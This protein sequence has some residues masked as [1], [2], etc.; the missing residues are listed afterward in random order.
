MM[1]SE[2]LMKLQGLFRELFQLD[3]ADLDFGLYRLLN[4][5]RHEIGDFLTKQLP[6]EVDEKFRILTE[7]D[8]A[9]YR[10]WL[11]KLEEQIREDLPPDTIL[12]NGDVKPAYRDAP[13]VKRYLDQ[14]ER[15][16]R[17]EA[18]EEQKADVFNHLFNFFSRYYDE[19]DF[20]PKRFYGS[21][22]NYAVPYNGEEVFF[23]WANKDQ[24]YVKTG[25]N[26]RDYNFK[27][28]GL[29]VVYRVRFA[30]TE[31]TTPKDNTKGEYRYFFP[32]PKKTSFDKKTK[33][34]ILPF[35]YRL[36]TAEEVQKYGTKTKGQDAILIEAVPKVMDAVPD[37]MLRD[38]L[39]EVVHKTDKEEVTLLL[40][41]LRHFTRK[42][43]TD[44]FIHKNLEGFLNQE[45]EFYIK[46]QMLHLADLE[47]DFDQKRLMLRV[48][49]G[50]ADNIITFLSQIE[51]VQKRLFEKKK[52]V[53]ET[54]YCI[55]LDRVPEEL[56]PEIVANDA[57]R[58]E[59]VKLFAINE[60]K[61]NMIVPAYSE[62]LTVEFLKANSYLVLDTKFYDL[63]LK[64]KLM[65]G[66]EDLDNQCD[67][68]LVHGENLQ[69]LSLLEK[70]MIEAV[71]CIYIDPPYN[72]GDDGFIYKDNY[73]HSTW[74]AMLQERLKHGMKFLSKEGVFF[75]SIDD[76]EFEYF[77]SL[78]RELFGKTNYIGN[79]VWE[80]KKKGAFLSSHIT[81]VKEYV[82]V[83]AK[84]LADFPGLIGE[85]SSK[86]E[87]YPCIN[88]SNP[89]D[90]RT[91]P[92]GISSK[93]RQDDY[94]LE[95][96]SVITSG[97]MNMILLSDLVISGKKLAQELII[98]G[99]W[100]YTQDKMTK[101][102]QDGDLYITQDLYLRRIVSDP[103][104]KMLKDLLPRVGEGKEHDFRRISINN[105]FDHGWGSNEDAN[106]ELLDLFGQQYLYD[107]PKP[108]KLIA[109][110]IAS[111]RNKEGFFLDY[112]A[113]SG[114][115]AEAVIRVNREDS[116]NR[117]FIL[118]EM[119]D[120]FN[121]VIIPRIKKAIY[122]KDWKH[123]KP[124]SR[125]GIS[126]MFKYIRLESYEDTLHNL[127]SDGTLARIKSKEE[128]YKAAKG[129]N[130][131]RIRYLAKLPLEASDT[132]LNIARLEHPFDY[133]LEV[134]T[135]DGPRAQTV[136][137]IETFNFLYGLFVR[138]LVTL[139][140]EKDG[141][142]YRIVKA[143]DR[144][145][146]KRI[147][148]VWRDMAD[149]DPKIE[150]KFLEGM[151][152]E[153]DEFDEKLING[154]TATPGF[155]SLDGLFKRLMEA[156]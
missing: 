145:G 59:W 13:L 61:G 49:R 95:K 45:L 42:N 36:P 92:P 65:A 103:R 31:A 110:L 151:L 120:Y 128:A 19:G 29:G 1:T 106:Q 12:P 70:N 147:L 113:G 100:R 76:C 32:Q 140:N 51:E 16:E 85:I 58:E 71:K 134:L 121:T 48:F 112:F 137:L 104:N 68:L 97:N 143:T 33:T 72:T 22:E 105:L 99:N 2:N 40:K 127:A 81:N 15:I 117:K 24:H 144:E 86:T 41:R 44:Y 93:Y 57:Q 10:E 74:I 136:D 88:A 132:M 14:K 6:K 108:T 83:L 26:F 80:K 69:A 124:I 135:D 138:R 8:K 56:Y 9:D 89:R 109:K 78:V 20:I 66:F 125:E 133:T 34:L 116:G 102:A 5:K 7:Q 141:R 30:L 47:A 53:L 27:V 82:V 131:Y 64:D 94:Y 84:S 23:H 63:G 60:I 28:E 153:E 146:S 25:E 18:S 17:I 35:E 154:D 114:T 77:G 111:T 150:R 55:T 87:T 142:D 101:F 139:K 3:M 130:E 115:S 54:N 119:G 67:G 155:Q 75:S 96:G 156:G 126:H 4:I 107:Y 52:F 129:E 21:R 43:T 39:G 91:I 50:L 98:E 38:L 11:E 46:D 118:V 122:S 149:L 152:K 62:P 123:G 79:L 73:K 148:V 90:V 37:D